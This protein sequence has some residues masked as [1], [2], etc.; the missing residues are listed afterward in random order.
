MQSIV[1]GVQIAILMVG[2]ILGGIGLGY[3]ADKY[4]GIFPWGVIV[5]IILGVAAGAMGI[6]NTVKNKS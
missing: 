1:L 6:Y 3:L 4:W 2:G 5:G